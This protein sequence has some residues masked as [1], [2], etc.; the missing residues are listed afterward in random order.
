[1]PCKNICVTLNTRH[2][3][4]I[5]KSDYKKCR[6]CSISIKTKEHI[7]PC[8]RKKLSIRRRHNYKNRVM[9]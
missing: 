5:Y 2:V 3:N 4:A 7:C 1:M 9:N 8:C 6:T